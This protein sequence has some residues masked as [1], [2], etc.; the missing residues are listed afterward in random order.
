MQLS[1]YRFFHLFHKLR[2]H[3]KF[4]EISCVYLNH[5]N[6]CQQSK[7]FQPHFNLNLFNDEKFIE[8]LRA[9][10]TARKSNLN[11]DHMLDLYRNYTKTK[12]KET[13]DELMSL[14]CE[15]PNFTHPLTPIGDSFKARHIYIHGSKREERWKLLDVI[16]ITSG[17]H[18]PVINHHNINSS[19]TINPED[20]LRVKDTTIGAGHKTYY[21]TGPLAQLESALVA[22]TVDRLKA[23]G[24]EFVSVPD[25]LPEPVI[26]ACGFQT[27]GIRSQIYKI[28]PPVSKLTYCLS[29][30]S[31]M[32]LAGF[33]AGRSFNC[34]SEND[35]ADES[36][37]SSALGLCS[38]SRC[39]R[40]EAPNQEPT[41]YRVHQFT[42]VEMFAITAPSLPVSDA[43]FNQIIKL[44]ICLFADLGLHFRVLEMPSEELGD[45]AYRKVD[46]EAWMPGDQI[47]GEIS[48][49]SICLDYQ[50]K[51]LNILWQTSSNQ[52]EF[53]YTLNGTACAI[54]R[55]MKALIETHQTQD[56]HIIVPHVLLPYMKMGNLYPAFQLKRVPSQK[57]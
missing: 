51:R 21:F 38:V 23:T 31:E 9:N 19:I 1:S 43:M 20:H 12:H 10:L 52:N 32:A 3:Y 53:A 33:C 16:N 55:I 46:I 57:L 27:Q 26:R 6:Y 22:Y 18:Q 47:Y 37:Q 15:L 24:F 49:S 29:G 17:T 5:H 25:I 50:S 8:N 48:S 35:K 13:H 30:T 39:F 40:K 56:K 11:L 7:S 4:N 42:K 34:T 44:Q 54:P 2:N 45:S 14:V 28:T 41:L 36:S